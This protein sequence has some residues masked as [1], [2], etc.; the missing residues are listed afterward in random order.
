[1]PRVTWPLLHDRPSVRLVL[2]PGDQPTTFDLLADTGAGS[3][4]SLFDLILLAKDCW[5]CGS[6][7]GWDVDLS[8]VYAGR[9]PL[10]VVRAQI[11]ALVFDD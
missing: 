10:F 3:N 6:L 5:Q 11:P 7:A 4:S 1:M 8:G 9:Y 2:M